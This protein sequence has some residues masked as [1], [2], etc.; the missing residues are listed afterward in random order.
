[1]KVGMMSKVN[2]F[3]A[4]NLPGVGDRM[5][6]KMVDEVKRDEPARDR[7]GALH[8]ASEDGRVHGDHGKK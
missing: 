4:K 8:R 6:A 2:T 3:V 1:V 7:E 5:S